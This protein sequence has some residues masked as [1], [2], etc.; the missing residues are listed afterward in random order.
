MEIHAMPIADSTTRPKS[1]RHGL[2][3]PIGMERIS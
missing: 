2:E 1:D 3:W